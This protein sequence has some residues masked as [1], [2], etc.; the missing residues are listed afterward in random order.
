MVYA[1]S[2]GSPTLMFFRLYMPEDRWTMVFD[3]VEPRPVIFAY[4][5]MVQQLRHHEFVGRVDLGNTNIEGYLF[6]AANLHRF[7]LVSWVNVRRNTP[8]R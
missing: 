7:V 6:H 4:R 5:I 8:S 1:W 3:R 2:Q